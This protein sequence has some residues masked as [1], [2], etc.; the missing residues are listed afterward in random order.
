MAGSGLKVFFDMFSQPSR[1]VLLFLQVNKVPY[2]PMLLKL[3]QGRQGERKGGAYG[4]CSMLYGLPNS[5]FHHLQEI[6]SLG[7]I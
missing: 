1:A 5:Y 2:E 3:S 6:R 7:K 4:T